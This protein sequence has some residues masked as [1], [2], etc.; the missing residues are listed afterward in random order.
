[1][2]SLSRARVTVQVHHATLD[3]VMA[4]DQAIDGQAKL[5]MPVSTSHLRQALDR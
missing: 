1:M 4:N 5:G 2:R 3:T